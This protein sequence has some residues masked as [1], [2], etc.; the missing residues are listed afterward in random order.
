MDEGF[1]RLDERT[2]AQGKK[3]EELSEDVNDLE[4]NLNTLTL[5]VNTLVSAVDNGAK[6]MKIINRVI[7]AVLIVLLLNAGTII[8]S[9]YV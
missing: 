2:I 1:D 7:I 8:W 5:N 4:S 3:I 6:T 9:N